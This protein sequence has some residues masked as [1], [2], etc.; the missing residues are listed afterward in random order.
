MNTRPASV[1]DMLKSWKAKNA[2]L[3]EIQGIHPYGAGR[4]KTA[5]QVV[6]KHRL[7]EYFLVNKLGFTWGDVHSMAEELEH[8]SSP[9]LITRLDEYLGN[10]AFDPHG[11]PIPDGEGQFQYDRAGKPATG[12]AE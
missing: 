12:S 6:R 4:K 7:W 9:E 1:T 5:V 10:P 11:D 2:S 3:P 8:V